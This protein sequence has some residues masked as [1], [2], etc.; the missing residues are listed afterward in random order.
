[1]ADR[2]QFQ[3]QSWAIRRALG[4]VN[5]R[6][7][8]RGSQEAE[9]TQPGAHLMAHL[10]TPKK[11]TVINQR[12]LVVDGLTNFASQKIEEESA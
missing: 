3:L 5:S 2:L 8:A 6:P 4:C 11:K 9:F 10:S 12:P 1:M 7:G